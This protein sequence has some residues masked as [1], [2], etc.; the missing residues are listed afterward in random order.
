MESVEKQEIEQDQSV[1]TNQHDEVDGEII[2]DGR[3]WYILQVFSGH[4]YKV[5]MRLDQVVDEKGLAD[6]VFRILIPE[7]EM[8]EIKD[9]KRVERVTK[10][11]PGYVFIQCLMDEQLCFEL[12]R[13]PS[14]GKFIGSGQGPTPVIEEDILKVL[15]KVGDKTKKVEVDFE[16]GE[17]IKVISGPFRGYSGPVSEMHADRGKVKSLISI[18]GRETPV[19]LDFDQIEKVVK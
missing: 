19:E 8:I 17:T 11:Y 7:E 2:E 1:D 13:V 12:Q 18:F 3:K 4:E 6:R 9:N 15:H 10:I 14:V 5:K 16:V